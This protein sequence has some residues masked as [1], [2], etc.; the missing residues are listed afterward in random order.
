M[1]RGWGREVAAGAGEG[2]G[3]EGGEE[4]EEEEEG[5]EEEGGELHFWN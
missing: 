5:C 3:G 4:E 2:V 1:G